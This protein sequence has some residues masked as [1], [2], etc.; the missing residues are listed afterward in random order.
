VPTPV[1]FLSKD[2]PSSRV[3]RMPQL[4]GGPKPVSLEMTA[5]PF[6]FSCLFSNTVRVSTFFSLPPMAA[7]SGFARSFILIPFPKKL[8]PPSSTLCPWKIS[9]GTTRGYK[10]WSLTANFLIFSLFP[11]TL[12]RTSARFL[13]MALVGLGSTLLWFTLRV[14]PK[15]SDH[16]APPSSPPISYWSHSYK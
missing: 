14:S 12:L 5:V 4:R 10:L 2:R 1:F 8:V 11:K 7:L 15:V 6:P 9:G 13:W 16:C 3:A